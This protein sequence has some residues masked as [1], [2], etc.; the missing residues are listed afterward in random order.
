MVLLNEVHRRP[1]L[2]S[3]EKLLEPALVCSHGPHHVNNV[4]VAT[5][6]LPVDVT[7]HLRL[8]G[9]VPADA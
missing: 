9:I 8:S 6:E 2:C 1:C 3:F 4:R 7:Q 5:R